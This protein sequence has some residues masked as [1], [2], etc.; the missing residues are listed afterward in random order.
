MITVGGLLYLCQH[1]QDAEQHQAEGQVMARLTQVCQHC[2]G[3]SQQAHQDV[4][5]R[6]RHLHTQE[7]TSLTPLHSAH[8]THQIC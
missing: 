7:H 6:Q 8:K 5:H 2:T 3:Y 1:H 4:S